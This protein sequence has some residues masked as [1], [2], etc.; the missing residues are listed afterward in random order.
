M[1]KLILF[2]ALASVVAAP[3]ALA[4]ERSISMI[5]APVAPKAGQAWTATIKVT[6]DDK[7]VEGMGPMVRVI[8]AAGKRIYVPSRATPAVGIYRARVVFPTAG[9]WRVLVV[10]RY[11]GRSYEFGRVRVRVS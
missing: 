11:S 1:R 4:K 2:A 6:I 10:D 8:S 5:G 7:L 3:A 9:L